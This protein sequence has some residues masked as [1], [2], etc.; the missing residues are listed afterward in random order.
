[1]DAALDFRRIT[2][3]YFLCKLPGDIDSDDDDMMEDRGPAAGV[4]GAKRRK[5]ERDGMGQLRVANSN[6][7]ANL[8]SLIEELNETR[9]RFRH[10]MQIIMKGL[11]ITENTHSET[12]HLGEAFIRFNFNY[13]YHQEGGHMRV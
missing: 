2:K 8:K 7:M 5:F 12:R 9:R 4:H 6:F 11:A 3:K 10:T 13:Y 1:M